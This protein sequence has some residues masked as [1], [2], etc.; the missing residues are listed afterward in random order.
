MLS[1][2]SC[3]VANEKRYRKLPVNGPDLGQIAEIR[4]AIVR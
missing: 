3:H 4:S 2:F 1:Q